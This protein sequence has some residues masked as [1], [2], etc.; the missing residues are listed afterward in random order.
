MT[1]DKNKKR[2]M[3]ISM[4]QWA[5]SALAIPTLIWAWDLSTEDK[6]QQQKIESL[7]VEVQKSDSHAE[8]LAAMN[9][10]LTNLKESINE[11]KRILRD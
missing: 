8:Q 3:I 4:A 9:A 1:E 5:L 2:S 7:K 10:N 11:I 6:L